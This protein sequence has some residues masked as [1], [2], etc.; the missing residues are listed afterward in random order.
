MEVQDVPLDRLTLFPDNPRRGN[1]KAIADSLSTF[2]QYKPI[3]VNKRNNEI[4]AG[5]HT[6]EAARL[7][8]WATISVAYVDVDDDTAKRIVA[9]DNRVSDMGEYDTEALIKLLGDL[10]DLDHT[11]YTYDDLDDLL[12]LQEEESTPDLQGDLA[13][14]TNQGVDRGSGIEDMV[15]LSDLKERYNDRATRMLVLDYQIE[16]YVWIVKHFTEIREAYGYTSNTEAVIRLL[17][18]RSGETA[19]RA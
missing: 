2:G 12:A 5:N 10:D 8:E 4:L 18:D 13:V 6:Y 16:T 9:I 7:L 1:I 14:T 19:P 3:T 11:G 15:K 17:E